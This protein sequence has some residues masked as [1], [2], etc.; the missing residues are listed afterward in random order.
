MRRILLA[1]AAVL[2]LTATASA[3]FKAIGGMCL[4]NGGLIPINASTG[5]PLGYVPQPLD[6]LYGSNNGGV[7]GSWYPL[8]CDAN[9]NLQTSMGNY[10]A[11]PSTCSTG[12]TYFNTANSTPYYCSATNSWTAFGGGG[13]SMTW[14]SSPGYALWQSGTSWSAPHL[15]DSG[16]GVASSLPFTAPSLVSGTPS[17]GA[18]AAL[19]T[20]AHGMSGDES[21]TAG[22]PAAGVDYL[23]F[24]STSHRVK[25]SVNNGAEVNVPIPSEIPAAQVAANLASSGSTGVIGQ[26]P[27]GQVGSAGLSGSGGV[28]I[29]STGAISLSLAGLRLWNCQPGVGDGLNAITAGTYL[30]HTCINKTGSTVT[31]TGVSCYVNGGSSSTMNASGTTLGALLTGAVTCTTAAAGAPG[32]Q[33][34]NVLLT[35]GDAIDFT[36]VADGTAKQTTW[37]VIGTY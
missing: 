6:Q 30:Q 1:L 29:A 21:S 24:D 22:V 2:L 25:Q 26:L 7:T 14:P 5:T 12:Q 19:P 36:F 10:A 37:A 18:L 35:N 32:T 11:A 27:I 31:I 33:S 15:T 13:G 34:A 28:S 9:G 23:R 20:G 17:A 16:T 4:Y 3:Q 8:A